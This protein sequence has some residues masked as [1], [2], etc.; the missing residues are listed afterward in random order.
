M[1]AYTYDLNIHQGET[2]SFAVQLLDNNEVA[3][4]LTSYT[5]AMKIKDSYGGNTVLSL[6]SSSG[7]TISTATGMITVLITAAQT[8]ALG[9]Q[10]GVYDLKVVSATSTVTYHLKGRVIVDPQVTE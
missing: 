8:A 9:I 6:T 3:I 7:I 5:A 1:P 4:D 10:E 2:R